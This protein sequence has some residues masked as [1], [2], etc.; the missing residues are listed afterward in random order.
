M[1]VKRMLR[2]LG[3]I[4]AIEAAAMTPGLF[5][6]IFTDDTAG[7]YG[8]NMTLLLMLVFFLISLLFSRNAD[9]RIYPL[10][11]LLFTGISWIVIC[12]LGGLPFYFSGEIPGFFDALFEAVSGFTTT[13]A[14]V[15]RNVENLGKGI[16]FWRSF[17]HWIGGMGVLVF[18]LAL[19]PSSGNNDAFSINILRAESPGP[20]VNKIVPRMRQS[21]GILYL[22]YTVM[23]AVNVAFLLGGGL[24]LFDSLCLAFGTAGTGGFGILN[25]SYASYPAYIQNITTVFMILFGVNFSLYFLLLLR[26]FREAL[27]DDELRFYILIICISTLAITLNCAGRCAGMKSFGSALQQAAFQVASIITTTGYSSTNFDVW[28]TFSKAVLLLLMF[29]GGCA[30]STAGGIKQIRVLILMRSLRRETHRIFHPNSVQVIRVNQ[31]QIDESAVS[32]INSYLTGYV[33]IL[34]ISILLVSADPGNFS[35]ETN[36][37]AVMATFNNV[38]PGLGA[39]GPSSNFSGYNTLS[40]F[41]MTIDMLLGR[42]EI[43]P[44]AALFSLR[45]R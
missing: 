25:S 20:G 1:N 24:P 19:L 8:F 2:I 33:L 3:W 30:G 35:L 36:L 31:D 17:S 16:L 40:T 43:L 28:P 5:I 22:I 12:L 27:L 38:G 39:V 45:R 26:R 13:G 29:T 14:S 32:S 23:T 37:S 21:A 44:I 41:I 10:Q 34:F 9:Q 11:G 4:I 42:L 18:F 6:S 15:V 7:I